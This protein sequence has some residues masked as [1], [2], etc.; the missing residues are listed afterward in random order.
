MNGNTDYTK[1]YK[2]YKY[3]YLQLYGGNGELNKITEKYNNEYLIYN[4]YKNFG[5]M[6]KSFECYDNLKQH[7][8]KY[9]NLIF[10]CSGDCVDEVLFINNLIDNGYRIGTVFFMD[11]IYNNEEYIQ[12]VRKFL[13]ECQNNKLIKK[14]KMIKSF[15]EL[16]KSVDNT[17]DDD[18]PSDIFY[19]LGSIDQEKI[20]NNSHS[21]HSIISLKFKLS[22]PSQMG[23][24][25][26]KYYIGTFINKIEQRS[27]L[28]D[29]AKKHKS[30]IDI[31]YPK[32]ILE[33]K[34]GNIYEHTFEQ[35]RQKHN[36]NKETSMYIDKKSELLQNLNKNDMIDNIIQK[37]EQQFKKPDTMENIIQKYEQHL[38]KTNIGE[39]SIYYEY[40]KNKREKSKNKI[41]EI[42]NC[43]EKL[44]YTD[45]Y[46]N[47]IFLCS[48][49]CI[50]EMSFIDDLTKYGYKVGTVLFVDNL[51]D[52]SYYKIFNE[53]VCNFLNECISGE[54]IKKYKLLKSFEE[55]YNS[56]DCTMSDN[57][58]NIFHEL[59]IYLNS[60]KIAESKKEEI[61]NNY[62]SDKSNNSYS[63]HSII[64]FG[65]QLNSLTIEQYR[66]DK[67]YLSLFFSKIKQLKQMSDKIKQQ[68][69]IDLYYPDHILEYQMGYDMIKSF[70]FEEFL[71]P[72]NLKIN[73]NIHI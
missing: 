13:D 16:V 46:I 59:Y 10:L 34:E 53:E 30:N 32:H 5:K 18:K 15:E 11:N 66:N 45:K 73:L 25:N 44:R 29:I 71:K 62:L 19:S 63:I 49:N 64:T 55:L 6:V 58:C 56:T 20:N 3:K 69:S 39:Y 60:K 9:L 36:I 8:N 7:I 43:H 37:Y 24:L 41:K 31:Y 67:K 26:D 50:G 22:S 54:F 17:M 61:K 70:T 47:L 65:F 33:Y 42:F 38:K 40:K 35:F 27:I 12:D 68:L 48:G 14:Y 21:I 57:T 72:Y 2:K 1:K 4:K 28:C 51:Y 52:K 23:L